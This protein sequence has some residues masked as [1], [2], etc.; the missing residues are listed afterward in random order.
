MIIFIY[1]Q[2]KKIKIT[3]V[4]KIEEK[5]ISPKYVANISQRKDNPSVIFH[6]L[7]QSLSP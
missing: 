1:F 6:I 2:I 5:F 7:L 3:I 4:E